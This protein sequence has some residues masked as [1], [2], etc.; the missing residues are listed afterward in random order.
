MRSATF[1]FLLPAWSV[2]PASVTLRERETSFFFG[3]SAARRPL[4]AA[5]FG[6]LTLRPCVWLPVEGHCAGILYGLVLL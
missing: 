1:V 4:R 6:Y 5:N 3:P 2:S